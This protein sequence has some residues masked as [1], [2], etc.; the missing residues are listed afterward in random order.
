MRFQRTFVAM[1]LYCLFSQGCSALEPEPLRGPTLEQ[2]PGTEAEK[3]E[4][5]RKH[6]GVI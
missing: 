3:E 1:L 2:L 5:F 4:Y 6:G